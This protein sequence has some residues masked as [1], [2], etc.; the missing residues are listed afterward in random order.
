MLVW[1]KEQLAAA[2]YTADVTGSECAVRTPGSPPN[3][4][5]IQDSMPRRPRLNKLE[6]V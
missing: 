6:T 1:I 2:G 4:I 3:E 5:Q